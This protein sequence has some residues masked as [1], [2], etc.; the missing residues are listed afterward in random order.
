M[1]DNIRL[2][3]SPS[4]GPSLPGDLNDDGLVSSADLDIVRS[5]WGE[6]VTAGDLSMGDASGDGTVNSADLDV[7]RA[8]LGQFHGGRAGNRV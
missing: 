7:V 8:K 4:G 5:H 3:V 6:T 1:F 2:S